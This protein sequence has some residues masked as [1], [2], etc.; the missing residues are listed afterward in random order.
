MA[1]INDRIEESD[2]TLVHGLMHTYAQVSRTRE[3]RSPYS[4]LF[5]DQCVISVGTDLNL[6][7]SGSS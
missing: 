4:M 5:I 6:E 7:G 1:Q 3:A 2:N